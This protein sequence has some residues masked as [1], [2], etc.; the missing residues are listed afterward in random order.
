[1]INLNRIQGNDVVATGGILAPGVD[2][3]K[4]MF[5]RCQPEY[6]GR[7]ES[8]TSTVAVHH[9]DNLPIDMHFKDAEHGERHIANTYASAIER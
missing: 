4:R 8:S 5:A 2:D 9:G 1:M 3:F 7:H 6:I